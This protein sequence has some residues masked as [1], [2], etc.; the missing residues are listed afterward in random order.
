MC[1]NKNCVFI[2]LITLNDENEKVIIHYDKY[3][4]VIFIQ[5][6]NPISDE[7]RDFQLTNYKLK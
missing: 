4:N 6:Y 2:N 7:Y 1:K 5:H 3:D